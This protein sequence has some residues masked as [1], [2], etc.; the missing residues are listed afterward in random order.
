MQKDLLTYAV[1]IVAV[2]GLFLGGGGA[3]TAEVQSIVKDATSNLGALSS[4]V[5]SYLNVND[6]F[7]WGGG[8]TGAI[9]T[10]TSA[11]TL[12][13][14][15]MADTNFIT[16]AASTTQPATTITLPAT[17][18]FPLGTDTGATR[19]WIFENPFTAAATTT[20]IAAGT[21]VDLQEPD[22][23]N[24]VIGINNYAYITC[25]RIPNTDIICKVDET[26]PAD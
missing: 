24:V 17:T 14:A 3:S 2:I 8:S 5:N 4:E 7:E 19:T 13:Y 21:G 12:T 15:N 20:T 25:T 23:Q 11:Y 9:D 10:V 26:I 1:G 6:W 18:T 22:G 16:F